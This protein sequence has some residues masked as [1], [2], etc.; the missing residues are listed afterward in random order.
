MTMEE[1]MLN[2]LKNK[3]MVVLMAGVMLGLGGCAASS[4]KIMN[5]SVNNAYKLAKDN[6]GI[7]YGP[8][9]SGADIASTVKS[10]CDGINNADSRCANQNDYLI[11]YVMPEFGFSAGGAPVFVLMP[12]SMNINFCKNNLA[13]DCT[14]LKVKAESGVFGTIVEVA[15]LPGENKCYWSGVGR[16]GGVSCPAYGWDYHKDL[17]NFD[18]ASLLTGNGVLSVSDK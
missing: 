6:S 5:G 18:A 10:A 14:Y 3:M 17:R 4:V 1:K 2:T 11:G 16:I 8:W 7:V 9:M 13:S 12:K 15:S